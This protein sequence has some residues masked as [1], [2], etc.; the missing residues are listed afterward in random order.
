MT[1]GGFFGLEFLVRRGKSGEA[2]RVN[3]IFFL[4]LQGE[5]K[6]GRAR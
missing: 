5:L 3:D 2:R 1:L 6:A 4:I